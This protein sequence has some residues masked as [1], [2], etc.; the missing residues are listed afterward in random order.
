MKNLV[1]FAKL[2]LLL[3]FEKTPSE[4]SR[5]APKLGE[6]SKEILLNLGYSEEKISS[7]VSEK[8]FSL[9]NKAAS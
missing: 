6:H 9:Q 1:T 5:P 3:D 8:N 4:I 7:L 2:D